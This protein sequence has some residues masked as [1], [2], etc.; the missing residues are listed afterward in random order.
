MPLP[1]LRLRILVHPGL[2]PRVTEVWPVSQ[3][4]EA[5]EGDALWPSRGR[6]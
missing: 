6:R 1:R 5:L 3:L 4:R 2:R